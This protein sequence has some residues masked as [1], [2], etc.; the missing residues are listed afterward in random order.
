VNIDKN[1]YCSSSEF[2]ESEVGK[3]YL[4]KKP[5]PS[6]PKFSREHCSVMQFFW[7]KILHAAK[8]RASGRSCL[9]GTMSGKY[10]KKVTVERFLPLKNT[11]LNKLKMLGSY[12]F[13]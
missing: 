10:M 9:S 1:F 3:K 5:R 2:E 8:K 13:F 6:T 4:T 11:L 12:L 7:Q